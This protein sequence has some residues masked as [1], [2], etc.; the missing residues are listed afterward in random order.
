MDPTRRA[1]AVR[2]KL[3]RSAAIEGVLLAAA[4]LDEGRLD[5]AL[6]LAQDAVAWADRD[7]EPVRLGGGSVVT[8]RAAARRI[9]ANV[10]L[11]LGPVA[12]AGPIAEEAERI[13]R[14]AKDVVEHARC[15]LVAAAV[16]FESGDSIGALKHAT[17]ARVLSTRAGSTSVRCVALSDASLY[18]WSAGDGARA[19]E[20]SERSL[21]LTPEDSPVDRMHVLLNAARLDA[22]AG[23]FARALDRIDDLEGIAR[24]AGL[25]PGVDSA[26]LRAF[27]YVDIGALDVAR[28]L[29][30]RRTL[31][32]AASD[33]SPVQIRAE[34]VRLRATIACAAGER[35]ETIEKLTAEGLSMGGVEAPMQR[36]FDRLRAIA[37]LARGR[38]EEAER[39][40]VKLASFAAQ[41]GRHAFGAQAFAVAAR[42]GHP[43]ASL[44]RWLGA[45]GLAAG[46]IAARVEYEGLAAMSSEPD[47]IGT[48]ARGLLG[49][50]RSR[51]LDHTPPPLRITMRRTLRQIETRAN[52]QRSAVRASLE[53][54]LDAEV[55]K[56]KEEVGLAGSSALLLSAIGTL[57]RAAKSDA[58][59]VITGETGSGKELFARLTH[60]LSDRFRGPFVAINCAAIP[61]ALLEAELFGHER[62]AFTGA[63]RARPGLFVEAEGGTLLLDELGEMSPAM[64][65]K[66]L[67]VLEDRIVR[68]VGG[69]RSRKV[70]VRVVAATH[71][72][73]AGLVSSGLFRED[74]YYRL[75]AITVR[76][77]SLRERPEDVPVICNALLLRDPATRAYRLDVPAMTALAEHEWPGNVREL[78]NALR[79]AAALVEG[80]VI[81]RDELA[82]AIGKAAGRAPGGRRSLEET[83]LSAL[84][85]RHRAEVRELVGRAIAGAGGNKRRAAG[86]LGV[87]RQGLY[88]VLGR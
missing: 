53:T 4:A 21:A 71:R 1:E 28:A 56:A 81:G 51:L 47:P 65:S 18:L 48:F 52:L 16:A 50:L 66:L 3:G 63:E 33:R 78:A 39:I 38:N 13:A 54:A 69:S 77:P 22:A 86:A 70:N 24:H 10:W 30:A 11:R 29:L 72:D 42:A 85:S 6:R 32:E 44:L 80:S 87:S 74:L 61:Q 27:V 34:L 55:L 83:T 49:L 19:R 15:E 67:R 57:A 14:G 43:S 40:S 37:L 88:R 60:R 12:T 84:R 5:E 31:Q 46:G 58:S 35:P 20:F 25:E 36:E 75:A 41:A 62:G 82:R 73:L 8:P 45:L 64:Q 26:L 23:S 7:P 2:G 17:R 76:V 59:L 79:V 68:P 9:L